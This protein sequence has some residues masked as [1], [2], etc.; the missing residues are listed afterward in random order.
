MLPQFYNGQNS[1][2][3]KLRRGDFGS[4]KRRPDEKEKTRNN[5]VATRFDDA[6]WREARS[7]EKVDQIV[8]EVYEGDQ[9]YVEKRDP[10]TGETRRELDGRPPYE[11]GPELIQDMFQTLYKTAPRFERKSHVE[12][13]A[14]LNR[15]ILEEI[16]ES[17]HYE[18]LHNKTAM[19]P[20]MSTMA[21]EAMWDYLREVL[22]REKDMVEDSNRERNG[23]PTQ[24]VCDYPVPTGG[25]KGKP[26]DG[27]EGTSED[28]QGEGQDGEGDG[29]GQGDAHTETGDEP[30]DGKG[31]NKAGSPPPIGGDE[32]DTEGDGQGGSGDTESED[33]S[34]EQDGDGDSPVQEGEDPTGDDDEYDGPTGDDIDYDEWD[35]ALDDTDIERLMNRAMQDVTKDLDEIDSVR[36]SCGIGEGEWRNLD[37]TTRLRLIEKFRTPEF[38]ALAEAIG[39][40][41]RYA[42]G[43]QATKI[44]DVEHEIYDVET[45]SDLRNVLSTEFALLANDKSKYEF[46]RRYTNGELLQYKLR[47]EEQAGKGPIIACTD[48][49]GSM[50]GSKMHWGIAVNEAL[51]RICQKQKRDFHAVFF[52]YGIRRVFEFDGGHDP[53]LNQLLDMLSVQASGGTSFMDV[54]DHALHRASTAFDE[55]SQGKADIVFI[56]DGAAGITD[57]WLQKFLAEKARVGCRIFGVFVSGANDYY[58]TPTQVLEQFSDVVIPVKDLTG[59]AVKEVFSRV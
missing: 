30:G 51:R 9:R 8:R 7:A 25:T 17:P 44:V 12:K 10:E 39:R 50:G 31:D 24:T 56:T 14:R 32:D 52:D 15:R 21:V 57:E 34:E 11:N 2:L 41:E 23:K 35:S 55:H 47:G 20:V 38:K 16:M 22:E 53:D 36:A 27:D 33:E 48:K 5:V 54:L 42:M 13:D 6:A 43:L 49:S 46:Y 59:Q 45:G 26:Q 18:R 40:L 19:D 29:G 1:F 37:P 28:G 4:K 3:D 58:G